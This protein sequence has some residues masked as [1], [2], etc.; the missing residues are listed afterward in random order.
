MMEG[1]THLLGLYYLKFNKFSTIETTDR[2]LLDSDY[3]PTTHSLRQY[4]FFINQES[5]VED[6]KGAVVVVMVWQLDL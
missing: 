6:T 4:F 2:I 3:S 5:F 1:T